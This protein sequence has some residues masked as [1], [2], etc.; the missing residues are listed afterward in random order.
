MTLVPEQIV[1]P[2][3]EVMLTTGVTFEFTVTVNEAETGPLPHAVFVPLTV[4]LPEADTPEKLTVIEFVF[5]PVAIDAPDGSVQ[6][7]PVA[8]VISGTAYATPDWP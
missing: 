8:F 2:T 4:I 6:T 7:Y 1:L 5:A 3:L